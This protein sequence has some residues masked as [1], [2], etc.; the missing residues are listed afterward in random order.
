MKSLESRLQLGL[1]ISL[2]ALL[3]A[4][5]WLLSATTGRIAEDLLASRL[6]HDA[7]S[8]L[9]ALVVGSDGTPRIAGDG[10][11]AIYQRPYSGHYFVISTG[12]APLIRSRSLW[13]RKLA[14][15][16]VA[17]GHA[18]RWQTVGPDGQLLL[19]W[20]GGYRKINRDLTITVA[21]DIT[22]LVRHLSR[23]RWLFAALG[24]G[25]LALLLALQRWVLHF[26]FRPLRGV[27]AEVDRLVAGELSQLSESVP[28][29]VQPV[30][31]EVNR[32]L[33]LLE[34]RLQ[35]SRNAA[36]NLAH[37]LKGPLSLLRQ[38][39][40]RPELKAHALLAAEIAE[41]V[42]RISRQVDTELKRA[43]IAGGGPVGQRF[44][45]DRDLPDLVE[46][47]KRIYAD[48]A[49]AYELDAGGATVFA[50]DRDDML[51]LLGNLLDNAT[52]WGKTRVRC[53]LT[54]SPRPMVVV[55][56]DGP[57][58]EPEQLTD[59]T[60]RGTRVDEGTAGHGLGLAIVHEIAGLYG[61]DVRL[62][63]SPQLGGLRAA[64]SFP[65]VEASG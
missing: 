2:S 62:D 56:D 22:P 27:A 29:E 3:V 39:A 24:A 44:R 48:K 50:V 30:V 46:V 49:L 8:L 13:D 10:M 19:A 32:L 36:G 52:K 60:R 57:G 18:R 58:C 26:S 11:G 9:A 61:A 14:S 37:A 47:L 1:A 33:V 4:V 35:R 16:P 51:E 17:V 55:E 31:R 7:E 12:S 20:S 65:G 53:T 42:D 23:L 41:Y 5:W 45:P 40:T 64:V 63:R 38:L 43:R 54:Q 59:L 34:Q 21:E 6:E 15:T 25:G 28:G